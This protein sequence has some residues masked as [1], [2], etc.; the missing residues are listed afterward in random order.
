MAAL[1]GVGVCAQWMRQ[2][3]GQSR[4]Q[5]CKAAIACIPE[6]AVAIWAS[7]EDPKRRMATPVGSPEAVLSTSTPWTLPHLH[8]KSCQS[9]YMDPASQAVQQA[10]GVG[11]AKM[12]LSSCVQVPNRFPVLV[13]AYAWSR[14][15]PRLSD[16]IVHAAPQPPLRGGWP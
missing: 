1:I 10:E 13:H 12:G 15:L 14:S 5:E 11:G 9:C 3:C 7:K 8:N 2:G 4:Q 16:G 6:R